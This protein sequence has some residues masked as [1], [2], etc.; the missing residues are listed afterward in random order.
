MRTG[1]YIGVAVLLLAAA[2]MFVPL[3]SSE[4][5]EAAPPTD[6]DFVVLWYLDTIELNAGDSQEIY[7]IV[8]NRETDPIRILINGFEYTDL[9]RV[10][11]SASGMIKINGGDTGEFRV[12][13]SSQKYAPTETGQIRVWFSIA[14]GVETNYD[15]YV[16][17]DVSISSIYSAGGS[18]NHILGVWESPFDD[19][20]ITAVVSFMIWLLIAF[21]ASYLIAP[22]ILFLFIDEKPEE[23]KGIRRAVAK[24]FIAL[25]ALF[26]LAQIGR[27][28]V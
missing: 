21:I 5:S 16:D 18:Y 28:H 10:S 11:A 14:M 9:D 25:I 13:I 26:G 22:T 17:I 1:K 4:D 24:P 12:T 6:V 23:R 15:L 20:L 19:A 27:A 8:K 7:I 2:M 3:T